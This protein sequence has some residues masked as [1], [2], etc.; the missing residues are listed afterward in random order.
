MKKI[1][2]LIII[3]FSFIASCSKNET[4]SLINIPKQ[5]NLDSGLSLQ[6]V[7]TLKSNISMIG[8]LNSFCIV[9]KK[10]FAT[11]QK[12]PAQVMLYDMSGRQLHEI[13]KN[14]SGP[15]EYINPSIVRSSEQ[16]IYVWCSTLLKLI[17]FDKSGNPIHE[18]KFKKAIKDFVVYKY[19]VCFY[20]AGGFD[21]PIIT[22]YD[23]STDEFIPQTYG[24]QSNEHKILATNS[25]SGGL[26][27]SGNNLFFALFD[28]PSIY[29]VNLDDFSISD[30]KINDPEFHVEKVKED[31][32]T[33]MTNRIK[34]IDYI[35]GSDII[36]G[37]FCTNNFVALRSEVGKI[38]IE[39]MQIVDYS[40][41]A[42]KNYVFNKKMNLQYVVRAGLNL[43][44]NLY[45]S[46]GDFLY[47]LK[48]LENEETYEL[49]KVDLY[50]Y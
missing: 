35:F 42:Q 29:K 8:I 3:S 30:Y 18:Y 12:K 49:N 23:M 14:G 28:E 15:Y 17:V 5:I 27:L 9:D 48:S 40:K 1:F 45:A 10:S 46:Q 11:S 19:H 32:R 47:T 13:G 16:N 44:C 39:N 22:I 33:F 38:E 6:P 26:A 4:F 36:T 24:I 25:A 20:A 37:I 21:D 50:H 7:V 2:L 34:S 43:G 31:A 41:R